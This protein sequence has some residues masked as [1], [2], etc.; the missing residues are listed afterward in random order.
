MGLFDFE[1]AETKVRNRTQLIKSLAQKLD[2]KHLTDIRQVTNKF[3]F[4]SS[5]DTKNCN[6]IVGN[7]KG[8]D[9]CFIEYYH[10]KCGKNDHSR[11]V[12]EVSLRF[13][14]NYPDFELETKSSAQIKAWLMMIFGLPFLG[15]PIF[16]ISQFLFFFFKIFKSGFDI[17]ILVPFFLFIGFGVLFGVIG[18]FVFSG[19][20]R[21]LKQI[22]NQGQYYIRNSKFKEKYVI[23][24]EA[25]VNRV[26]KTF[27]D[28]VC[29]KIVNF[30]PAIQSI[31]CSSNC[32]KS[33]FGRNEQLTYP[34]C[35]QHLEQ[36]AKQAEIFEDYESDDYD[37]SF[38]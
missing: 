30:I 33:E 32:L 11:W 7:Y 15:V 17:E 31:N 35:M 25:N 6:I 16:F 29:S 4:Y 28:K 13:N 24:T 8:F 22:Q 2:A 26:R 37:S 5:S 36:L 12:S 23:L 19:G 27:N 38:F 21:T 9:Y 3:S 14:N 1:T 18:W 34:L 20:F 10:K